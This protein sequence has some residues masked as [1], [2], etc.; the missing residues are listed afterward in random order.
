MTSHSAGRASK[1]AARAAVFFAMSL[2]APLAR[3][4]QGRRPVVLAYH[5]PD[6]A[7]FAAHLTAL[8]SR[9]SLVPLT[10]VL[11]ALEAGDLSALL[12]KQA[13]LT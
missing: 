1:R 10:A 7:T 11:D 5:D 13:A 2:F 12:T 3:A 6:P 4:A 8:S 9:H